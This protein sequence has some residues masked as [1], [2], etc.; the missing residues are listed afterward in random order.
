MNDTDSGKMV[1]R[2]EKGTF[3][4]KEEATYKVYK[5]FKMHGSQNCRSNSLKLVLAVQHEL[6]GA[7]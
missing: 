3:G 1:P 6:H 4:A 2:L 7:I 5:L